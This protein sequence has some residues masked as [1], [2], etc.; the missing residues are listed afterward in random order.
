MQRKHRKRCQHGEN[1][2]PI[3]WLFMAPPGCQRAF[4]TKAS[5][6]KMKD[7]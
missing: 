5:M 1:E 3:R 6:A 7:A 4:Q 2:K